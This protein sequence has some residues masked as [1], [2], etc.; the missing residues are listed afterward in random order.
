MSA[1]D[2]QDRPADQRRREPRFPLTGEDLAPRKQPPRPLATDYAEDEAAFP[3]F[4]DTR[5][6]RAGRPRHD[7]RPEE[8]RLAATSSDRDSA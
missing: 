1:S 8:R 4:A 3:T 6:D 7:L 5:P 2:D